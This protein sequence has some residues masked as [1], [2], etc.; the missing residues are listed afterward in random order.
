MEK[1]SVYGE[2]K[3][4]R[5]LGRFEIRNEYTAETINMHHLVDG[6]INTVAQDPGGDSENVD[7]EPNIPYNLLN[8]NASLDYDLS[9]DVSS[10][11]VGAI[12]IR[13]GASQHIQPQV[14]AVA[15]DLG[16]EGAIDVNLD[17]FNLAS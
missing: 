16:I 10:V 1:I 8:L 9:V 2:N 6:G 3:D 15:M 4:G 11:K 12:S 5:V 17:G 14:P 7:I 13:I